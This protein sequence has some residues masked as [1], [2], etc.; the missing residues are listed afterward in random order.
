MISP[1]LRLIDTH[2]HLDEMENLEAVLAEAKKAGVS[3]IVAVGSDMASN[4][5]TLDIAALYENFVY[6]ALGWHP[7][8]IKEADIS[9]NLEFIESHIDEAAAVGEV[10]LDYHKRVRAV[11]DKDL[12]KRVL[13]EIL[14]IARKHD[15][16]ALIHSRYAWRDAFELVKESGVE[17]A[18][19]HWYTGT[20]GVL[21]DVIAR[22]YYISVTP[23]VAYHEEHRRAV[24][25][26]PLERLLLETDCP[27]I[28]ARGRENEFTS[29]PADVQRSLR[30]AAALKGMGEA[31]M[32]EAT[33]ENAR[34]LFGMI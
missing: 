14:G 3:A 28:Y 9:T 17:K 4:K 1:V 33:T 8:N 6:P 16:L 18:V 27:V 13:K 5:K 15:K 31:E 2:A 7:W 20:S 32:A 19:F 26:T 21:R 34:K 10:G 22:G 12:Q 29:S 11:A 30:G 25:E 24:K 23:A